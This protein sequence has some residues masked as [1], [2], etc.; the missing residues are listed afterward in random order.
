[1]LFASI[2][3]KWHV[4]TLKELEQKIKRFFLLLLWV[5]YCLIF[6]FNG[7]ILEIRTVA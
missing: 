1:M 2:G 3:F 6:V 7:I 4:I 5:L